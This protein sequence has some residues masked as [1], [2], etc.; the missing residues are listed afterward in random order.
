M[1]LCMEK[2]DI[3]IDDVVSLIKAKLYVELRQKFSCEEVVRLYGIIDEAVNNCAEESEEEFDE[4][5]ELI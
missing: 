5:D 1:E 4:D 3:T 2:N